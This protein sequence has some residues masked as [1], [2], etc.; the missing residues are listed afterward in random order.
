MPGSDSWYT[1]EAAALL[2]AGVPGLS[3]DGL[4]ALQCLA[5]GCCSSTECS[6]ACSTLRRWHLDCGF[7]G[8]PAHD[9]VWRLVTRLGAEL[10]QPQ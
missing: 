7:P 3:A 8:V 2:E 4:S 10:Q 5:S 9:A 1:H 6:R